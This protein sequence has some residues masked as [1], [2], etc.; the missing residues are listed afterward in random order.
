LA[1]WLNFFNDAAV[2]SGRIPNYIHKDEK[3]VAIHCR[4][5]PCS[6]PTKNPL[7]KIWRKMVESNQNARRP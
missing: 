3:L 5:L 7:T 2:D 4:F 6:T 1:D